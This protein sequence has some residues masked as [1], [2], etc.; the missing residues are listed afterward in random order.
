MATKQAPKKPFKVGQKVNFVSRTRKGVG[1]INAIR[2]TMTGDYYD[3]R[4][5]NDNIVSVRAS[6]LTA[7]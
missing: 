7:I 4:Y 6:Q 5:D 3:V 2:A 1:K